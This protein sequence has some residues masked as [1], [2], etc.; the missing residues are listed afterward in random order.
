MQTESFKINDVV[1]K[2]LAQIPPYPSGHQADVSELFSFSVGV[3]KFLMV[4]TICRDPNQRSPTWLFKL[5]SDSTQELKL[6][7][8]HTLALFH[9]RNLAVGPEVKVGHERGRWLWIPDHGPD[10]PP[11]PMAAG[12]LFW[13]SENG[14][15]EMKNDLL[16]DQVA[17]AFDGCIW[18]NPENGDLFLYQCNIANTAP[19][20]LR[21]KDPKK[22]MDD[23][24]F[25]LPSE[26]RVKREKY[27]VSRI[28]SQD[29]EGVEI[30]LGADYSFEGQH[31]MERDLILRIPFQGVIERKA[32]D[33]PPRLKDKTW[34]TVEAL[35][36]SQSP[37]G[38]RSLLALYHDFGF[39]QGAAEVLTVGDQN[40]L[41][42]STVPLPLPSLAGKNV[43]IAR[44][45]IGDLSRSGHADIV[46]YLRA[47]EGE[48]K[49]ASTNLMVLRQNPSG[50][51]SYASCQ[52]G[53][54]AHYYVGGFFWGDRFVQLRFDGVFESTRFSF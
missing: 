34:S 41:T 46:L 23:L 42:R 1:R 30:Y 37:Q 5:G 12:P 2:D 11:Y 50:G 44:A 47:T 48:F 13:V 17:F 4:A 39:K 43:W 8:I 16:I 27:L 9:P 31:T 15:I 35:P 26:L 6:E 14:E 20:L 54:L 33:I 36:F 3:T 28:L 40:Q 45:A 49:F 52:E 51:F 24:S 25:R 32:V 22:P 21:W 19:R 18:A 7:L 29:S 10:V 38:Q 53:L